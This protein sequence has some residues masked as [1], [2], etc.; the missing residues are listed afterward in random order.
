MEMCV[1]GAVTG[2]KAP[3][4]RTQSNRQEGAANARAKVRAV[5]A[6]R[7]CRGLD[8]DTPWPM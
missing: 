7:S 1:L 5:S 2:L 3:N 8:V 6:I 4:L